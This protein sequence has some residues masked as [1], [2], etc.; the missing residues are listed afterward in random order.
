MKLRG[1]INLRIYKE[2]ADTSPFCSS[3]S[4]DYNMKMYV[5]ILYILNKR[6]IFSTTSLLWK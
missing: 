2:R 3:Y 1:H 5:N 6:I 4:R